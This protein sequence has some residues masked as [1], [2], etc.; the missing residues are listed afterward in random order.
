MNST[1]IFIYSNF[2]FSEKSA[3]KT[4]MLYYAKAIANNSHKVY[5][6]SCCSSK[7]NDKNF[8]EVEP[9]IFILEEKRLTKSFIGTLLFVKN[10]LIFSKHLAGKSSFIFYP[11]P[12][13]YLE[14]L[15]LVYIKGIR[16]Y[17]VFYEL[18]EVRKYSSAFHSAISINRIGYSIKKIVYKIIF[19]ALEP[20]LYF[21]SGLICISTNINDYGKRYNNNTIRIPILTNPKLEVKLSENKYNTESAYNIGF[22]GSI[23]PS[24]ENL[25]DFLEVLSK[26]MKKNNNVVLNLCGPIS[27]KDYKYI[28]EKIILQYKIVGKVNYYG[29]LNDVELSTFL[30]QQNLLII[31]RGYTLQNHFGFSTKLSDYLNHSKIILLTDISDNKLFIKDGINGFIVPP[32]DNQK[33]LEKLNYIIKNHENIESEIIKNAF[34]TSINEFNYEIFG[35]KLRSYL[36]TAS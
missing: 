7:I 34:Q 24:K 13:I 25:E 21:Y 20:L 6:V 3:G 33:M 8:I 26:T 4:R 11:S 15:S 18:N 5:L 36:T 32:N 14:V 1:N 16:K 35:D 23:K 17:P 9:N 29:N 19:S 27:K 10:L 12:L 2:D 22:S 31:P 28:F 30:N